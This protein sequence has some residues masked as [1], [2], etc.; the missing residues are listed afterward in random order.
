MKAKLFII[1]VIFL[2]STSCKKKER[3]IEIEETEVME[4]NYFTSSEVVLTYLKKPSGGYDTLVTLNSYAQRNYD[5]NGGQPLT[6]YA[7][8]NNQKTGINLNILNKT[9]L[10]SPSSYWVLSCVDAP[11]LN[12]N[13]NDTVSMPFFTDQNWFT[14][15]SVATTDSLV[16]DFSSFRNYDVI[17]VNYSSFYFFEV[18]PSNP[19]LTIPSF[20]NPQLTS[21]G[22]YAYIRV[23]INAINAS[24]I[25]PSSGITHDFSKEIGFNFNI[26]VYKK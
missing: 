9:S 12:V 7:T 16:L 6:V 2:L 13:Y 10:F 11:E 14:K 25:K 18:Y 20:Y 5:N 24:W 22:N 3:V 1:G 15:D 17:Q 26:K 4:K 19:Y 8:C 23:Y 21:P